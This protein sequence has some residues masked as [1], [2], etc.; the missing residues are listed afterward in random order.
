M[1]A[2][3]KALDVEHTHK[4]GSLLPTPNLPTTAH[5]IPMDA[6]GHTKYLMAVTPTNT[7]HGTGP[8][9]SPLLIL[10]KLAESLM[11]TTRICNEA[12]S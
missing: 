3:K 4:I 12:K 10:F 11:P 1:T 9:S 6:H 7:G 8:L 5:T 2:L